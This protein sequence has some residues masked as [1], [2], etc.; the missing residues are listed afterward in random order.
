MQSRTERSRLAYAQ[1]PATTKAM[2]KAL[3]DSI[4]SAKPGDFIVRKDGT[5]MRIKSLN[6]DYNGLVELH[7]W[8][9]TRMETYFIL[10][11]WVVW[12]V[13]DRLVKQTDPDAG[14]VALKFL[15][16]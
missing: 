15:N 2:T 10:R 13:V 9:T 16:Q 7:V 4:A 8:S 3:I 6:K 12:A 5:I 14:A 11:D 1:T